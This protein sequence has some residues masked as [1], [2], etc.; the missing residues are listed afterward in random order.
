MYLPGLKLWSTNKHYID[1]AMRLYELG[2]YNYIELYSVPGSYND[3]IRFW[4][5][6]EVPY[7]IH[8]PHYRSGLNL[9]Q[10][11]CKSKNLRLVEEALKFADTLNARNIIF[12][13]G[14]DGDTEETVIQLN[15]IKDRRILIENKPCMA[16]DGGLRCNGSSPEEINFIM[17]HANVGFCL[18]IGHAVCAANACKIFPLDYVRTFITLNPVMYHLTDGDYYS[19]YDRHDHFTKGNFPIKEICNLLP[20]K[21]YITVE[22][23]KDSN[24]N[25]ND[26][27]E[28]INYLTFIG[29]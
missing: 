12:H 22:T 23:V 17:K 15:E 26:F 14:V 18:D 24:D 9:S 7:S 8:G 4:K 10:K 1:E 13:P 29:V 27:I 11:E 2:F 25:L 20:D 5:E 19:L 21:C 16:L 28:D 6:L 3:F